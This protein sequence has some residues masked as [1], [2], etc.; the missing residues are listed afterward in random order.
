[1]LTKMTDEL[2]IASFF[3]FLSIIRCHNRIGCKG[4]VDE[5]NLGSGMVAEA[6]RK[7]SLKWNFK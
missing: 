1:M 6:E 7:R 2:E 4:N 3:F 5:E